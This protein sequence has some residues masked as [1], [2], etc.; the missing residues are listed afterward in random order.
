LDGVVFFVFTN[1]ASLRDFT[2]VSDVLVLP[3]SRPYGTCMTSFGVF[4]RCFANMSS[5]RDYAAVSDALVLPTFRPYGTLD[6]VVCCFL[7]TFRPYGILDGVVFFVFTNIS[8][9]RDLVA[10]PFGNDLRH[11]KC[12]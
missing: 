6:H 12:L 7:P 9:L 10:T 4:Y 3:T 8:S 2:G 5:L 11:T 1:M